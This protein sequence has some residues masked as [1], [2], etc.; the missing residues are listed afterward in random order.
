MYLNGWGY[1]SSL[2][3]SWVQITLVLM[4]IMGGNNNFIKFVFYESALE[5]QYQKECTT[6][7]IHFPPILT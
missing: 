5:S 1:M 2:R 7:I 3:R 6:I 4:T